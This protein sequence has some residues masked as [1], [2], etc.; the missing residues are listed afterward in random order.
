LFSTMDTVV[1]EKPLSFATSRIVTMIDVLCY[2]AADEN[3]A[4]FH[5]YTLKGSTA[6]RIVFES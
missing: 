2:K 3:P 4:C 1:E 5:A 6:L